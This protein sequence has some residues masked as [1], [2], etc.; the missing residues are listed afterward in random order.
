[1]QDECTKNVGSVRLKRARRV[2]RLVR[3]RL[4]PP[5]VLWQRCVYDRSIQHESNTRAIQTR[6]VKNSLE[7]PS[8]FYSRCCLRPW[9]KLSNSCVQFMAHKRHPWLPLLLLRWVWLQQ[10]LM[11]YEE[12]GERKRERERERKRKRGRENVYCM[13]ILQQREGEI[14]SGGDSLHLHTHQT[15][16]FNGYYGASG[17]KWCWKQVVLEARK[18]KWCR[19]LAN[20]SGVGSSQSSASTAHT[21]CSLS[22]A[23]TLDLG[24]HRQGESQRERLSF[25]DNHPA[26]ARKRDKGTEWKR[27]RVSIRYG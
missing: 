3:L 24:P 23:T 8:L 25:S 19:K 15:W 9:K 2:L 11:S 14:E 20:A 13:F 17:R 16:Q 21:R 27:S 4:Q 12:R 1:M 18:R 10:R 5:R 6:Q 26:P 22:N 7:T